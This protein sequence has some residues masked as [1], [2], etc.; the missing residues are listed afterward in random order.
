[1]VSDPNGNQLGSIP[2]HATIL[3]ASN[4]ITKLCTPINETAF[5]QKTNH[6]ELGSN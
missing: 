2:K 3:Q 1:M 5:T 6:E 4:E